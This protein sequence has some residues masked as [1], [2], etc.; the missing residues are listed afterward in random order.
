M[1]KY[2]DVVAKDPRSEV[3]E[4]YPIG[5]FLSVVKDGRSYLLHKQSSNVWI[6]IDPFKSESNHLLEV[7]NKKADGESVLKS[8]KSLQDQVTNVNKF[9]DETNKKVE[10]VRRN[11][12]SFTENITSQ[13]TNL[14]NKIAEATLKNEKEY[15]DKLVEQLKVSNSEE[16]RKLIMSSVKSMADSAKET[17]SRE[18]KSL[19]EKSEMSIQSKLTK[20]F[21]EKFAKVKEEAVSAAKES[22]K[23]ALAVLKI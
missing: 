14:G 20:A 4:T 22:F 7:L 18:I 15:I 6:E 9:F 12:S 3:S 2:F 23:S 11:Y 1:T 5:M 16:T 21:D 8:L 10:E 13:I 19:T 17:I